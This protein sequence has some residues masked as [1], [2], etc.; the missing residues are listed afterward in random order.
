[1]LI[2][3]SFHRMC[4]VA[5]LLVLTA[6][7]FPAQAD[8]DAG[9]IL[10]EQENLRRK[11]PTLLPEPIKEVVRPILI[12][13]GGEVVVIKSIH[14]TGVKNLVSEVDLQ[15]LVTSAIG[16]EHTFSQLNQLA[17]IVTDYLKFKG[18][19]LAR[20]YLPRQDLSDAELEIAILQG[21][22]DDKEA[23]YSVEPKSGETLRIKSST[24][25][26]IG[27]A[28]LRPGEPL[29]QEALERA[30]LLMND[31]P[32]IKAK[33][34][35]VQGG[36]TDTTRV[37][38][39]VSERP[40]FG[41]YGGVDNY[42][43]RSVGMLRENITA[44]VNDPLHIGDRLSVSGAHSS[45]VDVLRINY[46]IPV[47]F[48]GLRVGMD[49]SKMKYQLSGGV[50]TTAD[51]NGGAETQS[52]NAI[53]PFVRSRN[54]NLYGS[55]GY[56]HK[57]LQNFSG[58]VVMSDKAE[59]V[60]SLGL[61]TDVY[62]RLGGGGKTF[63]SLGLGAGN[64]DLSGN[65]AFALADSKA[66]RSAGNFSKL[67]Y[68]FAR[69]Q[70][71]PVGF[72]FY[73]GVSGQ[74]ASKNLD[75]GEKFSLGGP[76]AMRAY[77][78]DEASGDQGWLA[79]LDLRYELPATSFGQPRIFGFYDIG[80][81]TLHK[82]ARSFHIDTA[83]GENHYMLSGAGIGIAIEKNEQYLISLVWARKLG[84]NPGRTVAGMN[85]DGRNVDDQLW[86]QGS[87]MF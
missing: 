8:V 21:R 85:S 86:A 50:G 3:S 19:L 14:F 82:D 64:I 68:S 37:L 15:R 4:Q 34:R 55:L 72:M 71:L 87:F 69:L 61:S 5:V 66:Y 31:L 60:W 13:K 32:G 51:L 11:L 73:A 45:G 41:F 54:A 16:K 75:S 52:F 39:E 17:Q 1:M 81:I 53:Y 35:L 83:T 10:R 7:V 9:S 47:G 12:D 46:S 58:N 48:S 63:G 28:T 57:A 62:D 49:F 42:G 59:S 38:L 2:V 24:L 74:V 65:K 30:I 43:T 18:F 26:N 76:T 29:R 20:A 77:T 78:G 23:A 84:S 56:A 79:N 67:N 33:S 22:L 40:L 70:N 44:N 25:T 80:G 6:I 27:V 36:E